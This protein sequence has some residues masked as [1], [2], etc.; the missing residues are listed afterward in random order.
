[1]ALN[2]KASTHLA[3]LVKDHQQ[4][5]HCMISEH[6]EARRRVNDF[7]RRTLKAVLFTEQF[8]ARANAKTEERKVLAAKCK[9]LALIVQCLPE[10]AEEAEDLRACVAKLEEASKTKVSQVRA[11]RRTLDM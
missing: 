7:E 5:C 8:L 11:R 10:L 2:A 1:M 3:M 4:N 9:E 6:R